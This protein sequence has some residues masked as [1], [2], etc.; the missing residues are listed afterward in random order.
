MATYNIALTS[1]PAWVD[2]Q[3]PAQ[4]TVHLFNRYAYELEYRTDASQ[5]S[6]DAPGVPLRS[7]FGHPVTVG[8]GEK[9]WV[10]MPNAGPGSYTQVAIDA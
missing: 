10:R 9:L 8:A 3:I 4:K 7:P 6:T 5:P 1:G 2:A